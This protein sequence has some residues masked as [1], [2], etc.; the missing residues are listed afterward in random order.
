MRSV[1]YKLFV[2]FS[3]LNCI[4]EPVGW[5]AL[6]EWLMSF[7]ALEVFMC[8]QQT[9]CLCLTLSLNHIQKKGRTTFSLRLWAFSCCSEFTGVHKVSGSLMFVYGNVIPVAHNFPQ[10][11]AYPTVQKCYSTF[12]FFFFTWQAL[13]CRFW[14]S[15]CLMLFFQPLYVKWERFC[16]LHSPLS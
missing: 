11:L 6:F 12:F 8:N 4:I 9:V 3:V 1:V 16:L 2:K 14:V 15:L 7:F 10:T 13:M 5:A